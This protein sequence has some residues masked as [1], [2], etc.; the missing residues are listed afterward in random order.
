MYETVDTYNTRN[1]MN[2]ARIR[3]LVVSD[4]SVIFVDNSRLVEDKIR[5]LKIAL[6]FIRQ[7]NR[8]LISEESGLSIMT[9]CSIDYGKFRYEDRLEF[10]GVDKEFFL[11]Q[12]YINAYLD[13]EKLKRYP[14]KCRILTDFSSSNVDREGYHS[15]FLSKRRKR[16]RY[17][18]WMINNRNSKKDFDK[19]YRNAYRTKGTQKY[20][21]ISRLLRKY[22]DDVNIDLV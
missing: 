14:G 18:Y 22:I 19:E 9:T 17:F 7:I 12:P 21:A 16:Y 1:E 10:E 11:G 2:D 8:R 13:N 4:C 6:G 15:L 5:D 20:V 3:S